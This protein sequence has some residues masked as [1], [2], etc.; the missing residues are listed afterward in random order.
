[1]EKKIGNTTSKKAKD[2]LECGENQNYKASYYPKIFIP[3]IQLVSHPQEVGTVTFRRMRKL[4]LREVSYPK[5]HS[6]ARTL[7]MFS[8]LSVSRNLPCLQHSLRVQD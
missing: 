5:S 1:M 2:E 3:P 8:E 7:P 6:K 4:K